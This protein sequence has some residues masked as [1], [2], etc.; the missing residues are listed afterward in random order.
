MRILLEISACSILICMQSQKKRT[1][2]LFF[3][4]NFGIILTFL[5]EN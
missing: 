1:Y 2:L 5:I 4:M 3:K